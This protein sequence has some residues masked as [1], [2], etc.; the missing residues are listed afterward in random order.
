MRRLY[1]VL[2]AVL[3]PCLLFAQAGEGEPTGFSVS[4]TL[5]GEGE[6]VAFANVLLMSASDSSLVKAELSGDDGSFSITADSGRYFVQ[7]VML[8]YDD[9]QG[10]AFTLSQNLSLGNVQLQA[11]AKTLAT[12][13]VTSKKPFLEVTTAVA[14]VLAKACSCTLPSD[15]FC[16]SVKAAP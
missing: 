1:A 14:R 3:L 11:F 9:F 5:L 8:G 12:A 10:A 15:R 2:Y 13:G 16:E 6:P 7:V 4:G